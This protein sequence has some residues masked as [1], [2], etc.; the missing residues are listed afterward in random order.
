MTA[1]L[2]LNGQASSSDIPKDAGSTRRTANEATS[3]RCQPL[4]FG[5]DRQ[6][7]AAHGW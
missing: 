4:F 1:Y 5:R 2:R 3:E 7:Q 6:E